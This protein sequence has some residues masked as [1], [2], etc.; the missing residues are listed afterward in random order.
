MICTAEICIKAQNN[1]YGIMIDSLNK[2]NFVKDLFSKVHIVTYLTII[3]CQILF[4]EFDVILISKFYNLEN[5]MINN[6]DIFTLNVKFNV[7]SVEMSSILLMLIPMA[8][9]LCH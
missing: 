5:F 6:D 9:P 7:Y 4:G 1:V 2:E 3:I 8:F